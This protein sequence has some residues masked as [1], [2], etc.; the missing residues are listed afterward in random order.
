MQYATLCKDL[1]YEIYTPYSNLQ[2]NL[3]C[4]FEN[5]IHPYFYINPVKSEHLSDSPPV[6]L[7]YDIVKNKLN[8]EL[9][10]RNDIKVEMN[11]TSKVNRKNMED[12]SEIKT[13]TWKGVGKGEMEGFEGLEWISEKLTG[14]RI[15]LEETTNESMEYTVYTYGRMVGAHT[16][17]VRKNNLILIINFYGLIFLVK[18]AILGVR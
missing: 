1:N 6:Y 4:F 16:D 14:L 13:S 8:E 3:K 5:S 18:W 10:L 11:R 17:V 2:K 7:Y 9:K 15:S 12:R